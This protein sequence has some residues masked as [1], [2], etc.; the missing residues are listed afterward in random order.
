VLVRRSRR[1]Q[2]MGVPSL[3]F[4][5][6]VSLGSGVTLGILS[7]GGFPNASNTGVPAGTTLTPSGSVTTSANG[8]V[9]DALDITGT[10]AINHTGVLVKRCRIRQ[11]NVTS[12]VEPNA[13][14][15][16]IEDC[17]IDGNL[18]GSTGIELRNLVQCYRLNIH[19]CENGGNVE[20]NAGRLEDC[21][22]HSLSSEATGF[23][24]DGLQFDSNAS[25]LTIE[26]CNFVP[27]PSGVRDATSCINV[28]N[29]PGGTN[30]NITI[31]NSRID[32][33]GTN[34]ACYF[35]RFSG[36][37]NIVVTN[38]RILAGDTGYSDTGSNTTTWTGNVDDL[39]EAV[40][41]P[42]D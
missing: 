18:T 38:N 9:I 17:E 1:V 3:P 21:Y 39:T 24:S 2:G 27:V 8:Q 40:V 12:I 34:V 7:S 31:N 23:H 15:C 22:I 19:G 14:G 5:A 6:G 37:S 26:H 33:R 16:V 11:S 13:S 36:W 4:L 32:G 29:D 30:S 41:G 10:L 25:N 35:P 20:V 42:N 28:F